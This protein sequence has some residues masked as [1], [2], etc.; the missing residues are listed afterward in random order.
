MPEVTTEENKEATTKANEIKAG[1]AGFYGTMEYHRFSVLSP[2]VITDG[3]KYLCEK[4]ESFWFL[5]IIASY[6]KQCAK[7]SMLCDMQFWTLKV[8]EGKGIVTCDRD[9]GDTAITQAIPHTDFPLDEIKLYVANG[10]ILL[11]SEY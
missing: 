4:A 9:K 2:L 8:A 3:V 1:L 5:D 7:D 11:P 10:V 6:Q